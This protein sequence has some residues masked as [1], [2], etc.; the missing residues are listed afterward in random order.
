MV[1]HVKPPHGAP[2]L[3]MEV[4]AFRVLAVLPL[5]QIR[6]RIVRPLPSLWDQVPA[7]FLWSLWATQHTHDHDFK[8]SEGQSYCRPQ[9]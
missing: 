9:K 6:A 8:Q 5:T 2:M 3:C 1:L 7:S 4:V